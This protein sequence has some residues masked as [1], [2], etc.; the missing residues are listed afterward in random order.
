MIRLPLFCFVVLSLAASAS[1]SRP[2]IVLMMADDMGISDIGC[3]GGEIDTPRLNQ[4]AENGVR[5]SQFYNT[6]RCCPTRASL[7]TG[8]YP[9]QAGVGHMME[10]R[11]LS[12]YQGNLNR[13]CRTI[14][15]VLHPAGYKTYM[16]GKWHVARDRMPEGPKFNWPRQRGFDRFYGTIHG[17]GSFF[18]PNSLTRDNEQIAPDEEPFYYTNAIGNNAARFINEHQGGD[19]F[20][21]YVAFTSPHWP[22]QALENDMEKYKGK[23]DKGWDALREARLKRMIDIGLI[24]PEWKMTDRDPGAPAWE[25]ERMKT[26]MAR[27]MEVYAAMVDCMDQNVGKVV[28]AL[29]SKGMFEN[30][31]IL[32]L[33]DNGGCAEEFGSGGE[34]RPPLGAEMATPMKP[35]E[36]QLDMVPKITRDGKPVRQGKGVMPGAAD[37]YVAYGLPW[38]NAS[39]T[40]FRRYKHWVHEG[41]ISSPLIAHWPQGMADDRKNKLE[42]RPGHLIDVM[43]TCVD[44]AEAEYP[45]SANGEPIHPMEG[46]SLLPLIEGKGEWQRSQPL[47]WEHEGNRAVRDG[48]WKLVATLA[49]GEWELYDIER[50]RTETTDLAH[51]YPERVRAM[52]AMWQNWAIR[53]NV[54]P[55]IWDK[56]Q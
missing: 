49:K 56:K 14:A 35:G 32:F 54:L 34:V 11:G 53:A 46:V 26:W 50:D 37:T 43:A 13:Q 2:N 18:D 10:D 17:A 28:D 19:P 8:L 40:P 47:F 41:G 39:N 33:A 20:F 25:D 15:E 31:L 24:K 36:L 21:L 27:R 7:L 48:K 1:G 38:A 5:F 51:Q 3:Y 42:H 23:Y 4:L 30:T 22:M 52:A 9:H 16:S 55:W 29:K 44:V 6:S 45:K 12:G